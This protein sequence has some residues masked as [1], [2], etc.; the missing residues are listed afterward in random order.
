MKAEAT[1]GDLAV[2]DRALEPGCSFLVQAPAGS[3]KTELLIQRLLRLL[4]VVRQPEEILAITFTRK[5]AA[6]MRERVLLALA[7]GRRGERPVEP[8]LQQGFEL[9][10]AA[11]ARDRELGWGLAEQPG[12]LRIGTIDSVN[13]WLSSRAPLSAGLQAMS[14]VTENP[15]ALYRE[16]ARQTLSLAAEPDAH[17]DAIRALLHHCDNQAELAAGLLGRMLARRDQ[18]LRHTGSGEVTAAGREA[19]EAAAGVLVE[20][21]LRRADARLPAEP[22][23]ELAELLAFAANNLSAAGIESDLTAWRDGPA[24]P[25]AAGNNVGLWRGLAQALLTKTGGWRQAKGVNVRL[26]FPKDAGDEK[27]RMVALL[28]QLARDE[29]LGE[30]LHEVQ[31]LPDARY[32]DTQWQVLAAMLRVLPLAAAMLQQVFDARGETDF[33]QIAA[34]AL[35]SLG[36]DDTIGELS[37]VL[38][39]SLRHILLDEYQD[40][41]RSQHDLLCRLTA[42]WEPGDG[43]TVFLVGDPMQSIYRFREAEVGIF[44]QTRARGIHELPLEFLRL[45]TNFRSVPAIVGWVNRCF[46]AILPEAE[47]PATGAVP[48]APSRAIRADAEDTGVQWHVRADADPDAEAHDIVAIVRDSLERWPQD[49]VGILVRSRA[50]A[51][52]LGPLLRASGIGYSAPDLEL[53][54][55]EPVIQDLLAL[56][57]AL[58]HAADRIAWLALLR[59]PWCGLTLADLHALAADDRDNGIWSLVNDTDRIARLSADGRARASAFAEKL[60]PWLA[61]RGACALREVVEGA[62]QCIGGPACVQDPMELEIAAEFFDYLDEIDA[63]GDCPDVAELLAGID[64]RPVSRDAIHDPRV[65]LMTMHKAKGLEFDTV[66]LPGLNHR[67]RTDTRPL[68]LWHELVDADG[69]LQLVL[70]PR[71]ARGAAQDPL[72]ETLWRVERQRAAYEQQRLLYVAATRARRRLH[73]FAGLPAADDPDSVQAGPGSL[74]LSLWPAAATEVRAAL[75]DAAPAVAAPEGPQ[76]FDVPLRRLPAQWASPLDDTLPVW[77]DGEVED[78]DA[79]ATQETAWVRAAGTVAH[80][81]L[82]AIAGEGPEAFDRAR[83]AKLRPTICRQLQQ[84]GTSAD[85]LDAGCDRVCAA[86]TRCLEDER[87]RWLLSTTHTQA[88]SEFA[89]SQTVAPGEVMELRLDRTFVDG[90]GQRWIVDF[91]ISEPASGQTE[92]AFLSEQAALYQAQLARYREAIAKLDPRPRPV[93]L[94][95]YLPLLPRLLEVPLTGAAVSE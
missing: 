53:L 86:L 80:R 61:R 33:T 91:K 68:L 78:K 62:W 84:H 22:R 55:A 63:G 44:L 34:Q 77:G 56:T 16:A 40:T 72:F 18:W 43:R 65:Q 30:L 71:Q 26:G 94:A 29:L 85:R 88:E 79:W 5:A 45:E 2:R 73:L 49:T 15:D 1:P 12:R 60:A 41:S 82:Q 37:L 23:A 4:A 75:R 69:R 32:S 52:R 3:G 31:Q 76:W 95:L 57:R 19:L 83:V 39:Y 70:A 11:D 17:G 58:S 24:F 46:G 59:A 81:W 51:A 10:R 6:E 21:S 20:T 66:L 13:T 67:P 87:G 64:A 27:A 89:I 7:R 48:L 50:H 35:T 92:A 36:S 9:A 42:G 38:D 93:R 14:R 47:D 25:P 54:G 28:E 74:L 8:H 90:D